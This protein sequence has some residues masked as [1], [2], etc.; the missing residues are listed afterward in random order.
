MIQ[1]LIGILFMCGSLGA[2]ISKIT[3]D[4]GFKKTRQ[5]TRPLT[6]DKE[7]VS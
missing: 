4:Y 1:L 3:T 6:I 5:H 7:V 2:T